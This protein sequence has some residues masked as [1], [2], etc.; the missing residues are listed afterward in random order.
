[1]RASSLRIINRRHQPVLAWN[2]GLFLLII[3]AC[4]IT[5]VL[6]SDRPCYTWFRIQLHNI[7]YYSGVNDVRDGRHI[8]DEDEEEVRV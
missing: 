3:L 2:I 5:S 7:C 4:R 6:V 8:K 1:M